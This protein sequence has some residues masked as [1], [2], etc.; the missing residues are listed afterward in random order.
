M[1]QEAERAERLAAFAGYTVDDALLAEA[2]PD[3][4]V[5]H[6]LPAHPGRGDRGGRPLRPPERRLGRGGEPAA[7]GKGGAGADLA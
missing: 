2:D 3:A 6:C 7:H 1:G 5:L 4:I